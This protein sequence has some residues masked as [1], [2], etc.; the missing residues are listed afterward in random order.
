MAPPSHCE[1]YL[2]NNELQN[3][4]ARQRERKINSHGY[5]ILFWVI[6]I[7]NEFPFLT[8]LEK[9]KKNQQQQKTHREK[10][11]SLLHVH[12]YADF[13]HLSSECFSMLMIPVVT[14]IPNI[15]SFTGEDR[16]HCAWVRHLGHSSKVSL[17]KKDIRFVGIW[18]AH[19]Y[20]T[21]L[22]KNPIDIVSN[23]AWSNSIYL[24]A[25]FP[26]IIGCFLVWKKA[27]L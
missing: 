7:I 25:V 23:F 16:L 5:H 19:I 18:L 9:K 22:K 8:C 6:Q 1:W 10:W 27:T 21:E 12:I 4:K 11:R 2:Y 14:D 15:L 20:N 26:V 3:K 17:Q 13:H 24:K